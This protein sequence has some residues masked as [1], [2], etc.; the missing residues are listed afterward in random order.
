ME[1]S[2][3]KHLLVSYSTGSISQVDMNV[4]LD[5]VS[6]HHGDTNLDALLEEVLEETDAETNLPVDS[7]ALYR[8]I[9]T[10]PQFAEKPRSMR[11]TYWWWT[12]VAAAS[13]AF[14]FF[15]FR[16]SSFRESGNEQKQKLAQVA[17]E[18]R[19]TVTAAST[20]KPIL[21]LADGRV[22]DLDSMSNGL[23]AMEG[24]TQIRLEGNALHYEG[25]A[26]DANG[27]M[28]R[29]TIIT[30]K[31]RQYQVVLPDGSKM[32][33]NAA[34][35]L[36]YP[37]RFV[38]ERREVEIM[39]EAYFEVKKANNWPFIVKTKSQQ[40]EVLGTSFNV[41]AYDDDASTKTTLVE[42]SVKVSSGGG[43]T[44]AQ[45]TGAQTRSFDHS[46]T[47]RPGQQ[48][49]TRKGVGNISV[50]AIDVEDAVSWK[51]NLFVF[52]NEEISEVMKKVTR[53][54]DVEVEYMDGMAGKRI[55]GSIP[56][57]DKIE[58]LMDALQATKVLQYK[59]KGGIVVIMK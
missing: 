44:G 7:E 18:T 49:V 26:V 37:V 28:I 25:E 22:I 38:G 52:N 11:R 47:L 51:E 33:L 32:W 45:T 59:I 10:H 13:L 29:N 24:G 21:R 14:V 4:L 19:R 3:L 2:R 9:I 56:R 34:T 40:V 48:A 17:T 20:D 39:G 35:T 50:N 54:Y 16:D 46:A 12:G 30:P 57:F 5:Y 31:G 8:R 53:W 6:Q 15:I 23:L 42:G 27:Q 41:S 55:G 36:I 1:R 43:P 58:E